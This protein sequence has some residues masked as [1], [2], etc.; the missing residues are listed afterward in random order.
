MSDLQHKQ[1]FKKILKNYTV[2]DT[3]RSILLDLDLVVFSGITSSG[4][5]TIVDRLVETG[6]YHRLVSD[7]T[8]SPRPGE[9]NGLEYWFKTENE[10]LE[11]VKKGSYLEAALVHDRQI[12]GT[13][14]D[15]LIRAHNQDKIAINEVDVK[16][17]ETL[18]ALKPTTTVIFVIPPSIE[19]WQAR[20]HSRGKMTDEELKC[21]IASAKNELTVAI[22]TPYYHFLVN[23]DLDKAVSDAESIIKGRIDGSHEVTGR[24]LAA[25]LLVDI[26]KL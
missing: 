24:E 10:V 7:T 21:R 18:V 11:S 8:R 9:S 14:I 22:N 20:I 23:D 25:R 26:S 2:D 16:G 15:E 4:K 17:V 5:N 19:I 1:E 13:H 12:S 6:N 3:T